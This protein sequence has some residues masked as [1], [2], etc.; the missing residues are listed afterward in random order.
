MRDKVNEI[1]DEDAND[2]WTNAWRHE[3][4][5]LVPGINCCLKRKER[6]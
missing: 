1:Y 4:C 2:M 5:F 6:A 3:N